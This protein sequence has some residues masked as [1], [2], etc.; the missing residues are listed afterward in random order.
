MRSWRATTSCFK[1]RQLQQ[2]TD[3]NRRPMTQATCVQL[4]SRAAQL[5]F[6]KQ[7][8]SV[9][10]STLPLHSVR[11]SALNAFS[12]A[13]VKACPWARLQK[14]FVTRP[15]QHLALPFSVV[16]L[17]GRIWRWDWKSRRRS[18][19]FSGWCEGPTPPR[20]RRLTSS[21]Q[22]SPCSPPTSMWYGGSFGRPHCLTVSCLG[23]CADHGAPQGLLRVAS[24]PDTTQLRHAITPFGTFQFRPWVACI[25][26]GVPVSEGRRSR[27]F[28]NRLTCRKRRMRE[29]I[30]W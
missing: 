1:W 7:S 22:M 5:L 15:W 28:L 10:A 12:T 20:C 21:I 3:L 9:V 19:S 11:R 18:S 25:H 17:C 30:C 14:H 29:R 27:R 16:Q 6:R 2:I 8:A 26:R 23:M 4:G 24:P 13:H